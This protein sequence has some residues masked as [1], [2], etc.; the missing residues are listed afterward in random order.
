MKV[1]VTGA[2]GYLGSHLVK[3]LLEQDHRVIILKRS[4][5]DT[6]RIA[7]VLPR[8]ESYDVD[9]CELSLPFEEHGLIDAI[10][11]TAT[12]YG[13][14]GESAQEI[15]ETNTAFP[16]RLLEVATFFKTETFLNTDTILPRD[17]NV[18]ALSKKQFAEWGKVYAEQGRIR[19]VN[20]LLE[21]FYGP[22]DDDS[23]FTTWVIK[24][25]LKNVPELKLTAGEQKRDFIYIDDV[26]DAYLFLMDNMR[27]FGVAYREIGLGSGTAV[28]IRQFVKLVHRFTGSSTK[29]H[30][31]AIPYRPNEQMDIKADIHDLN[32]LGWRPNTNLEQGLNRIIGHS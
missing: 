13:R 25:C 2:T 15:F 10:M 12:A 8:L 3:A 5:S 20:I 14:R 21:H 19:F 7:E 9:R 27:N 22:D 31:G 30:F 23:K 28:T 11:H 17:L 4:T 1:L 29:L 6:R 26:V 16:L 32:E 24:S 18:Y